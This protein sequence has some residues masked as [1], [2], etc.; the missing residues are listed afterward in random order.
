MYDIN[1]CDKIK[2][3]QGIFYLGES[4][5]YNSVGYLEL[6]PNTSLTLHKRS[7]GIE[8]LTQ[9]EGSCVIIVFDKPKGTN[10]KLN[11]N[12]K[13]SIQPEGV[14]HI[15]ANPFNKKSIT[16]WHFQ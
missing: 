16:Y 2:I 11:E 3:E 6:N 10:H 1:K 15:H 8:N 14:W 13:L 12:D 4:N 7:N 9:V 5:E